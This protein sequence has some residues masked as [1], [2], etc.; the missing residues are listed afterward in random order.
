MS[1]QTCQRRVCFCSLEGSRDG[2]DRFSSRDTVEWNAARP[3]FT[4]YEKICRHPFSLWN[5]RQIDVIHTL[6]F[7]WFVIPTDIGTGYQHGIGY[8]RVSRSHLILNCSA[9]L[10]PTHARSDLRNIRYLFRVDTA[11]H[12]LYWL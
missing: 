9:V 6:I 12:L 5:Q 1:A 8:P 3:M 7:R 10:C 11:F 4:D 2:R